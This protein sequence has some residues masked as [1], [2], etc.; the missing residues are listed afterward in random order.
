[1]HRHTASAHDGHGTA[2][3]AAWCGAKNCN[4]C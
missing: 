1:V 2:A 3:D 4:W